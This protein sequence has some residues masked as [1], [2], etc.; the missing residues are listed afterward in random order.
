MYMHILFVTR[1]IDVKRLCHLKIN[2]EER[3]LHQSTIRLL[4]FHI[5]TCQYYQAH[6]IVHVGIGV[7]DIHAANVVGGKMA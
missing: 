2:K 6:C 1:D 7:N 5:I 4:K 3:L